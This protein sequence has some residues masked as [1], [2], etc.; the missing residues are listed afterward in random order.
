L[1]VAP[2][3]EVAGQTKWKG[4]A[5]GG[6]WNNAANWTAGIPDQNSTAQFEPLIGNPP[7][8]TIYDLP[9][10]IQSL[11]VLAGVPSISVGRN[12]PTDLLNVNQFINVA[13]GSTLTFSAGLG[14][15]TLSSPLNTSGGGGT[16]I[17]E[18]PSFLSGSNHTAGTVLVNSTVNGGISAAN[19]N[20]TIGGNGTIT[21]NLGVQPGNLTAGTG[22]G[23]ST[24]N[25]GGGLN[26]NDSP[27]FVRLFGT[28]YT[29]AN[30]ADISKVAV[31]GSSTVNNSTIRLDL[32]ALTL[33]Q[34]QTLRSA[35]QMGGGF[36]DYNVLT[37]SSMNGGFTSPLVIDNLGN[38]ASGEWT[39][40]TASGPSVVLRF[41]PVP[42]PAT[43]GAVFAAGLLLSAGW[44]R[45]RQRSARCSVMASGAGA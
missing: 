6:N 29:D 13:S 44:R 2:G 33:G 45:W 10:A 1:V 18:G 5:S 3:G 31:T 30:T 43:A 8:S 28:G 41:T 9:T 20:A 40:Q 4:P 38:F 19:S 17:L 14:S 39:L 16:I 23:T 32:S 12:N 34:V 37:T 25:V 11:T 15:S 27:Y 22:V 24:L 26:L 36:R 35:T 7:I 21:N 42:E